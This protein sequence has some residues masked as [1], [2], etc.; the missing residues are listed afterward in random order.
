MPV[1]S[2]IK[3]TELKK[4]LHKYAEYDYENKATVSMQNQLSA[5]E[6]FDKDEVLI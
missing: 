2:A 5:L 3:N 4:I 1:I 6:K